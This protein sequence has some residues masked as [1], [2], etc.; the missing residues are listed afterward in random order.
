VYASSLGETIWLG[1][2]LGM[3]KGPLVA[4]VIE[5]AI[6]RGKKTRKKKREGEKKCVRFASVPRVETHIRL[7]IIH[8]IFFSIPR[9]RSHR[10]F[11]PQLCPQFATALGQPIIHRKEKLTP[12]PF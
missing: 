6:G 10:R 5:R 4:L 9:G 12:V 11:L 1:V 8:P 2:G 3:E 7:I